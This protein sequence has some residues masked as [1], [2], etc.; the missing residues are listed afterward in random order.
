MHYVLVARPDDADVYST[1]EN[2]GY[3]F[4]EVANLLRNSAD[5]SF[6]VLDTTH[7]SDDERYSLYIDGAVA[8]AGTRYRVA[9]VFGSNRHPGEDFG[10]RVPG[11]LVYAE[12]GDAYPV[13]VYPHENRDGEMVTIA[14]HLSAS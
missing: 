12:K 13:D 7:Q 6:E 3:V 9:R 14:A 4:D 11:L 1:P 5:D 8:A 2:A 10:W